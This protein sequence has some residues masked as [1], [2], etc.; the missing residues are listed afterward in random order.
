MNTEQ[1]IMN[2]EVLGNPRFNIG[3]FLFIIRY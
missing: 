3:Y 1:G 2:T